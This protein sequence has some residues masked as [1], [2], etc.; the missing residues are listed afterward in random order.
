MKFKM[1][2]S[3]TPKIVNKFTCCQ[4]TIGS[5]P[6]ILDTDL[7]TVI[8]WLILKTRRGNRKSDRKIKGRREM[9]KGEEQKVRGARRV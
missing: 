7:F 6:L 3:P 9:R 1:K 4:F 8:I 2:I 5:F